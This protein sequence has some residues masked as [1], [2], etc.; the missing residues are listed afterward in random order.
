[1]AKSASFTV[2][3]GTDVKSETFI[4]VGGGIFGL[5]T[6]LWLRK[7]KPECNIVLIDPTALAN[8]KAASHDISKIGRNDYPNLPYAKLAIEALRYW[9]TD[10]FW[11]PFFHQVGMIRAEP[12]NHKDKNHN[13][14][15]QDVLD[16]LGHQSGARWMT[17]DEVRAE[18]PAFAT[19][20]FEGLDRV[21]YNPQCGWFEAA[22]ALEAARQKA[23]DEGAKLITAEVTT[24]LFNS[25]GDCTG[26]GLDN[27]HEV[28]GVVLLCT[29]ARTPSLLAESAPEQKELHAG[30]RVVATGAIS[31]TTS[32]Q[33]AHKDTF[34]GIPVLKN[35]LPSVKGESMSMTPDGTLKFNCDMAFTYHQFH[36]I[37]GKSMSLAPS[38]PNLTEWTSEEG[39]P[40]RLREQ[41]RKTLRGLYGD[42]M[43][44]KVIEKYRVCWDATTPGHDFLISP[45]SRCKNLY[46]ATGGSFHAWKFFP[47]I[48]E[49][50]VKMMHGK[51]EPEYADMWAWDRKPGGQVANATYDIEGDLG[52]WIKDEEVQG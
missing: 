1:M 49:Y 30:N 33:G 51:L 44:G 39:V 24:L 18:W 19:A 4:V 28:K 47:V 5:S 8:P 42:E 34:E 52:E 31:F 10:S 11:N 26:V 48:G 43:Q 29:G 36:A 9:Q 15:A 27:G 25:T 50:V 16:T 22:N 13:E 38:S 3:Q 45:H 17:P 21:R 41:A 7:Y 35:R 12:V 6:I 20:D 37:T 32:V 14:K 2:P 40:K 23:I 46:I